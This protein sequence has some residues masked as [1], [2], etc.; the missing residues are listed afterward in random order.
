MGSARARRRAADPVATTSPPRDA[1]PAPAAYTTLYGTA[2]P[3]TSY[4]GYGGNAKESAK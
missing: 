4:G 2:S 3:P 1:A